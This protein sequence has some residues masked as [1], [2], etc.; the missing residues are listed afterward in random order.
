VASDGSTLPEG[1]DPA[2]GKGLGMKIIRSLVERI[3]GELR[4]GRGDN[5]QG[6]RFTVLFS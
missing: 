1:F 4:I 2:A 3:G 5:N 6:A